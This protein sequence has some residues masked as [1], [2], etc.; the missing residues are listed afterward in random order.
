MPW[1]YW[2]TLQ[3]KPLGNI[4]TTFNVPDRE[5]LMSNTLRF[6]ELT[7]FSVG[8]VVLAIATAALRLLPHRWKL[9]GL[10]IYERTWPAFG[11]SFVFL[12][13][14]FGQSV[15]P[16]RISGALDYG[17]WPILQ[18]LH[19]EKRGLQFHET[20]VKVRGYRGEPESVSISWNDRRLFQY[21]FRQKY[22][23]GKLPQ[24]FMERIRAAIQS[25]DSTRKTED[26]VK[27]LRAW[28]VDGWYILGEGIGLRAYTSD[29]GP[30]PPKEIVELFDEVA[31]I[32]RVPATQSEMKDVCLG[33]C[34]DA[35]SA[36]GLLYANHRCP[37]DSTKQRY[38]CR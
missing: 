3:D 6:A 8:C 4:W 20:C 38:I 19:V 14:W 28:N 22:G 16:Y 23:S 32:P 21:R 5:L 30:T 11:A 10:P 9:R 7:I 36:L 31:R 26:S 24:S 2:T 1:I 15:M 27:P 18:I 33:F 34:Y 35:L 37:Y 25:S 29:K 13:I 17:G 12:A